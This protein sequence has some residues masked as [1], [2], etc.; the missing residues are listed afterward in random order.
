MIK[1]WPGVMPG[2]GLFRVCGRA[3]CGRWVIR[4]RWTWV[5]TASA[6]VSDPRWTA[7]DDESSVPGRCLIVAQWLACCVDDL[8]V[9]AC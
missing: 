4:S 2:S 9:R 7:R 1:P 5:D 3:W 6:G 8:M